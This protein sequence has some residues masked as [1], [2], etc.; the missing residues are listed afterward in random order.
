M[1]RDPNGT[2]QHAQGAKMDFGKPPVRL[3]LHA[4]PRAILAVS[5]VG[6]FGAAKYT[7]NGWCEVPDGITRYTDAMLR[8]ALQ[9]GIE[10]YDKDSE[11]RHAAQVAWNALARLE[12][13]L[14]KSPNA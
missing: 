1:E 8:H 3:I 10:E 11:L 6:G 5:E 2:D 9:E 4:M 14:R 7:D 13:I 12:L